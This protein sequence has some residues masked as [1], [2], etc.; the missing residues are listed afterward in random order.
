ML[1]LEQHHQGSWQAAPVAGA[2]A[3]FDAWVQASEE[4]LRRP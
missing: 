1:R 2:A 4:W 3:L